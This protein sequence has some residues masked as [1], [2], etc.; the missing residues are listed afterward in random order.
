MLINDEG[1]HGMVEKCDTRTL[2]AGNHIVYVE[3][4]QA[5]GGVGM[6]LQYSGPDTGG[7]KVFMRSGGSPI[8]ATK[9][10]S[11]F[12][13]CDPAAAIASTSFTM[14]MF[15]SEV[16]LSQIPTL[17][18]ADTGMNRLYYLG[19]GTMPTINL[20]DYNQFQS[21][22]P[23]VPDAN[24]AWVIYGSIK[25][26]TE[27]SYDLCI[28]SDDGSRLFV[29]GALLVDNEGLHGALE[30]C[31]TL[32]LTKGPHVIYIEGFQ[33]GGGVYMDAKYFGPDTGEG[34]VYMM[35]GKASSR[36]YPQ[37]DPTDKDAAGDASMF[38][39]CM[40]S[41][42]VGLGVTPRIGDAV[43]TN[44]LKYLGKGQI[45][46]VDMHDVFNFR[47]IAQNTPDSNYVWA[48]YGAL[49]IV[50]EGSYNLCISSD[51][52]YCIEHDLPLSISL[53]YVY[54][55]MILRF[56]GPNCTSMRSL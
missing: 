41:S 34:K 46:M 38:T 29:D 50:K 1:L 22:V 45:A 39:V 9:A 19:K 23:N 6:E 5:G 16:G 17:A 32:S 33:A 26:V 35:A 54:D 3:G 36:Y 25:I 30:K 55:I 2:S 43:T 47:Q 52:G 12:K 10:G 37:C 48:I 18:D 44:Q 42:D 24:Y 20:R 15:R 49:K 21:V 28:T 27:G 40:F 51:D 53:I 14:C 7:Q 13:Q 11:Y 31:G 8:T 4:F 56:S